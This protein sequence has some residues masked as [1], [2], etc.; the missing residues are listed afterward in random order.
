MDLYKVGH[1]HDYIIWVFVSII[2]LRDLRNANEIKSTRLLVQARN[3]LVRGR[4]KAT[5][6]QIGGF[7][8]KMVS[9]L[10]V[11]NDQVEA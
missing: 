7:A 11:E 5:N 6:P 3:A 4:K 10:A 1:K 8:T 2:G 9:M